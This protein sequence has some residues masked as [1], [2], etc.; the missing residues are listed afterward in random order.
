MFEKYYKKNKDVK[1]N[2]YAYSPPGSELGDYTLD[3]RDRVGLVTV[4]KY[5]EYKEV[6]FN[7]V[8]SGTI[9]TYYGEEWE[10]SMCKQVM[11]VAY[12]AGIDKYIVG[13]QAFYELSFIES[14]I[15][16]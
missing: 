9:A 6:G 10:T 7:V 14:F 15:F 3:K 4:D 8:M 1:F 13:D 5:R 12:E 2:F 11:D 16:H